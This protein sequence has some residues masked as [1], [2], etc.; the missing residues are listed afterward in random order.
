M[1]TVLT[2]MVYEA[3]YIPYELTPMHF[4]H[5][6]TN[7]W[8]VQKSPKRQ[9]KE[10]MSLNSENKAIL[11]FKITFKNEN[12]SIVH[13]KIN[14]WMKVTITLILQKSKNS[15]NTYLVHVSWLHC[16]RFSIL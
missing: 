16:P 14:T 6:K 5:K 7:K 3:I 9:S 13:N 4:I 1:D 10:S 11:N 15:L 12:S 2:H 8:Q